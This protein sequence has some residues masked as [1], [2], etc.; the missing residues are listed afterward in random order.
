MVV[1]C[2]RIL[3]VVKVQPVLEAVGDYWS[4][5]EGG[6][7]QVFGNSVSSSAEAVREF[8]ERFKCWR[9]VGVGG[10]SSPRA[11]LLL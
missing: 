1:F 7:Q 10:V 8:L 4:G 2:C 9:P 3:S 11:H 6:T 5:S